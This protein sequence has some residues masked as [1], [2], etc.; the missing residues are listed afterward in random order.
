MQELSHPASSSRAH[1]RGVALIL[2]ILFTI[3]TVGIVTTGMLML[4]ATQMKTETNFRLHGQAAQFANAGLIES[5]GWFRRQS[6]QPVVAFSPQRNTATTPPI[7]D[8]DDADIGIAREFEISGVIWGRYEVW[9]QWDADPDPARLAWRQ[10]VQ[11]TDVSAQRGAAGAG[12]VWRIRSVGYVY[13]RIDGGYRFDQ[14]PNQVLGTEILEVELRRLSLSPPGAAAVC[15]ETGSGVV[16][17]SKVRVVGGG[18]AGIFYR[19]GTGTPSV[20]AGSV[21]GSP[22][23]A[24]ST[25]YDASV[26]AV[27]G[28]DQNELRSLADDRI[29]SSA[30]FPSPMPLKSLYYVDVPTLAFTAARRLEG[31]GIVYVKGNVTIAAGSNSFFTGFLYVDGN[32]TIIAPVEFN[33]A[34]V[35]TGT[36]ALA[37]VSDFVNVNYD[38]SALNMLRTEIGQYRLSGAIHSITAGE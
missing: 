24:P 36:L 33:G 25:T 37:G 17:N 20:A 16:T 32:V 35:C 22:A 12:N 3:V 8:T 19:S 38:S 10:K 1:E 26:R 29:T 4:H 30:A 14:A 21:T 23:L 9:K 15:V 11:V 28:V 13:R 5:L 6:A 7:L 18:G 27:F 2:G 34:L 31:N